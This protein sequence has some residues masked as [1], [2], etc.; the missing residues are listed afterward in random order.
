MTIAQ[1]RRVA[2]IDRHGTLA[3]IDLHDLRAL[4]FDD[5]IRDCLAAAVEHPG[6]ADRDD[7]RGRLLRNRG[8]GRDS[9][10]D[11]GRQHRGDGSS[12]SRREATHGD[13]SGKEAG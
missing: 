12:G 5:A 11:D 13:S 7:G 6:G 10:N 3:L 1:E 9:E 2:E 4:D 8:S